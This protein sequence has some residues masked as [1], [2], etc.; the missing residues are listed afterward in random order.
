MT[1]KAS[2]NFKNMKKPE[3]EKYSVRNSGS[4]MLLEQIYHVS[5]IDS[6]L[7]IVA[8]GKIKASLV[9]DE[10]KL[11][12]K[13]ILVCWLS[14]NDWRGA[15]GYRYGNIRFTF[16]WNKICE[17]TYSYWVEVID[18]KIPACRILLSDQNHRRHLSPFDP[19][20]DDGPWW[21]DEEKGEHYWNG[22]YCLEIMVERD[23][24]ISE[25]VKVSFVDHHPRYCCLSNNCNDMG[26]SGSEGGAFFISGMVGQDIYHR[27]P[28]FYENDDGIEIDYMFERSCM[29]IWHSFNQIEKFKGSIIPKDKAA[30][31][32]ARAVLN[33]YAYNED[34]LIPLASLFK[35]KNSLVYSCAKLIAKKFKISD[36]KMLLPKPRKTRHRN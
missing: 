16:D 30:I 32:L 9:Y 22:N 7:N 4:L 10:S 21:Y 33:A 24:R 13:R 11:N 19:T 35:S 27:L 3:W 8:D 14:P 17:D 12:K 20:T 1:T 29:S 18:Y 26:I 5:H 15:G 34:D 25:V 36:W 2:E 6:A 23:I 31:P 28:A